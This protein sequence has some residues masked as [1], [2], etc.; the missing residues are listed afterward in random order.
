MYKKFLD[1]VC[2]KNFNAIRVFVGIFLNSPLQSLLHIF[3]LHLGR[4]LSSFHNNLLLELLN[5]KFHEWSSKQ[6]QNYDKDPL[7][8]HRI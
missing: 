6:K 8:I 5:T 4:V 7:N 2:H 3:A 1:T